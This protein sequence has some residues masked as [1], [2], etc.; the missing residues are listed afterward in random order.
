MASSGRVLHK[1]ERPPSSVRSK[2]PISNS[3]RSVTPTSRTRPQPLDTDP[4]SERV[5]VAV[6]LRPRNSEE[7]LDADYSDCVELQPELKRLNLRKNNWSSESFKFDEVLSESAS[8]KRVY[9]VVA[10]PVV[11]SVLDGYNGTIMAY[12]QTGTGKTYTLGSVGKDDA[13][14]RGIMIRALEDIITNASVSDTVEISY[15]QLYM[16][17]VQDLLAPEKINIPI[18]EDAKIGEVSVPGAAIIKITNL[19]HFLQLLQIGETNRHAANTKMNT[20]SS[21]SHAILMV[22]IRRSAHEKEEID[23]SYQ[24]NDSTTN[25]HGHHLP[26]IRKSKLLIV[27]LAGS[28]RINKSGSEGHLLEEA[29]CI[30]LSLTSLGKCINAL[31]EHSPHIPTRDSKLTRLLRDSFGGSARTSLIVTIGPSSRNYAETT[32]TI[33]FGQ[34]AMKVVNTVKLKEEFDYESLCRTLENQVDHLNAEIDRQQK[35]REKDNNEIEKKLKEFQ[36]SSAEAEKSLVVRTEFLEKENTQLKSDTKGLVKELDSLKEQNSMLLNEITRVQTSLKNSKFL[37]KENTRLELML[38]DV[39]KD[40]NSQKDHNDFMHSEVARLE[41]NLKNSKLQQLENSTYQK[42]LADTTQMYEKKIADLMKQLENECARSDNAE[43]QLER[44][45]KRLSDADKSLQMEN[46]GYQ[47]ALAETTRMYEERIAELNQQLEDEHAHFDGVE[48]QL[49]STEK[50]LNDNQN[51]VKIYEEKE[52]LELRMR[53]EEMHEAAVHELQQLNM[54]YKN[55]QL[56]KEGLSDELH[57]MRQNLQVEEKRR[58]QAENELLNIK[59]IVPESEDAIEVKK[60]YMQEISK[61]SSAFH[62]EQGLQVPSQS[63]DSITGGHKSTIAKICE[64]VGIPKILS[65]LTSRD[66]DVQIHAVKVVAN[67]AAEDIN[68]EKIV[69]EGGLDALLALLESSQNPTALRVASGAIANLAMNEMNQSLI[70]SKG[71]AQLLANIASKTDDPQTLRMVA[72]A[73]AN[74]CGN[75]KLHVMLKEDGAIKALL[76]MA[77]TGN[78]DVVAQVARGLA[79]FAKCES[80]RIIQG[81]W[82]GRSLL[83]EDGALSWL[84]ANGNTTSTSTRRHIE[85]A[86]CHLAQNEDNAKYFVSSGGFKEL[87][88]IS[89][90]STRDD[91]RSLAKKTIRLSP[92]FQTVMRAE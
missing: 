24:G 6:R 11:E 32:S 1:S 69:Q 23:V 55:L 80:R 22:Y 40:L 27:D 87:I 7:L 34:R 21:R 71:G 51:A 18:V 12:G 91:I 79:N 72:G 30:N 37:E 4:E 44:M 90:S 81:Y 16:E 33:M 13:S 53:L 63:R 66:V 9:E 89:N 17:A 29:K 28:E 70:T 54:E 59:K 78:A 2:V 46:A 60:P 31:A 48:E 61:G 36:K 73:I 65:L 20:E 56:E 42:L 43:E 57:T 5:R 25:R 3:R 19:D 50:L 38:N 92:S 68:Q 47:R 75:E 45:K 86:I 41:M 85:L 77:R 67:L 14:E 26:T 74:L 62:N 35:L 83:I 49:H 10:K 82:R 88:E 8:Q 76:G 84:V 39:L 64:E 58:K 52:I 15:L